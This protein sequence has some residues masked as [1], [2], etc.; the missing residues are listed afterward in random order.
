MHQMQMWSDLTLVPFPRSQKAPQSWTRTHTTSPATWRAAAT[1]ARRGA[2]RSPSSRS[3]SR[4][5]RSPAWPRGKRRPSLRRTRPSA[6]R[7]RQM[8]L[9]CC[10]SRNQSWVS[11]LL[12]RSLAISHNL[13]TVT[14]NHDH[15][16]FY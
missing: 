6:W 8:R 1:R 15:F 5:T 9:K 10:W 7:W 16:K 3:R 13:I 2:T 12:A 14:I 4:R 11:D